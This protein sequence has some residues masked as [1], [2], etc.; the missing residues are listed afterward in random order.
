MGTELGE[1][2]QRYE[3]GPGIILPPLRDLPGVATVSEQVAA[4]PRGSGPRP[5]KRSTKLAR[6]LNV[7]L[8]AAASTRASRRLSRRSAADDVVL[9]Y[10]DAQAARLAVLDPG[11]RRDEPDALHQMRVC[12]R[13]LRAALQA[14]PM[15]F[16]P[17]ATRHLKDELRWL[18]Q[19]LGEARDIEVLMEACQ[20]ALAV[21]PAED[22]LGPAEARVTVHFASREAEA[23]QAVL[24]ALDS[25]RYFTLLDELDAFRSEPPRG[26]AA[27]APAAEILPHAVGQAYRRTGRGM[28]RAGQ[29]PPGPE[30]D[31]LLHEA[32]KA[33]KRARYAA[34]AA[35]PVA[36]K[37]ARRFAR[38]MKALQSLLGDQHDAVT[39]RA[40][41]REIAV[42]AHLAGESAFSFGLLHERFS[43]EALRSQ[44]QAKEAW[45][46]ATRRNGRRWLR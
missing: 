44:R 29:A 27:T 14:F 34:E 30:R 42:H 40:A 10:L 26:A 11:V 36:G 33:A 8:P 7:D 39:A 9:A 32:R 5:A 21:M 1:E 31:L 37:Q 35:Q 20:S 2:E 18:G 17:A 13:R 3:G 38:R 23:R 16:P 12:A 19:V 4:R 24:D 41:A 28:R 15:V 43:H 22:V 25:P 46:R 45:K 6:A